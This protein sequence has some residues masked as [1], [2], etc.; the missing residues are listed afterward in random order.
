MS[1]IKLGSLALIASLIYWWSLLWHSFKLT[2]HTLLFLNT[3]GTIA[4][5]FF[6]WHVT[7]G[8]LL[9]PILIIYTMST[10]A[11]LKLPL[12]TK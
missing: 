10:S 12:K 1:I 5:T 6:T 9:I 2:K 11:I 3:V 8:I 4:M 7:Y